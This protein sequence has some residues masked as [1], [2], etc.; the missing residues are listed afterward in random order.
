MSTTDTDIHARID[1]LEKQVAR[2]EK[3]TGWQLI[4][5]VA[6]GLIVFYLGFQAVVL[7]GVWLLHT[8]TGG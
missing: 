6:I 5:R 3:L 1:A 4:P 7:V 8:I 2:L